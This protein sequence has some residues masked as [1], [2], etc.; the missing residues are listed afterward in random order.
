MKKA[1]FAFVAAIGLALLHSN[2]RR[3]IEKQE[4]QHNGLVDLN[5][6]LLMNSKSFVVDGSSTVQ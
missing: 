4:Q 6:R 5:V 2:T 1:I 3:N